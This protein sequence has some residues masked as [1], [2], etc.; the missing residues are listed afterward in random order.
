[1]FSVYLMP[2]LS[3]S[4]SNHRPSFNRINTSLEPTQWFSLSYFF[5]PFR[6][7]QWGSETKPWLSDSLT[8]RMVCHRSTLINIESFDCLRHS[9]RHVKLFNTTRKRII[10]VAVLHQVCLDNTLFLLSFPI[11]DMSDLELE[12]AAMA[13]CTS[14][15]LMTLARCYTQGL[16]E[17]NIWLLQLIQSVNL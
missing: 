2:S 16:L 13:C 3:I 14:S 5:G 12:R 4:K 7:C 9:V 6:L 17:L 11:S 10:W 8:L 15:I 1:M